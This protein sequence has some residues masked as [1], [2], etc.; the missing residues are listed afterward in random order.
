VLAQGAA[1]MMKSY[2]SSSAVVANPPAWAVTKVVMDVLV[3]KVPVVATV[4]W[5]EGFS[6]RLDVSTIDSN[7]GACWDAL[8]TGSVGLVKVDADAPKSG[9]HVEDDGFGLGTSSLAPLG[10]GAS[11][12]YCSS[13]PRVGGT[14]TIGHHH[15]ARVLH[16]EGKKI[17]CRW[18][19]TFHRP[20]SC[21]G[22][23]PM[24]PSECR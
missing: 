19:E 8:V 18:G 13:G 14:L 16:G 20:P 22:M 10:L 21:G 4:E 5:V 6:P 24:H 11:S 9:A 15:V 23:A 3:V 7:V 17:C 1:W 2:P 12:G